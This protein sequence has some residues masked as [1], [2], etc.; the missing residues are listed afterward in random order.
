MSELELGLK[1]KEMYDNAQGKTNTFVLLFGIKYADEIKRNN[2]SVKEIVN[3]SG[4]PKSY[5]VPVNNGINLSKY[6]NI[7]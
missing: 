3:S 5:I 1:L 2:L 4:L 6:V 7:K